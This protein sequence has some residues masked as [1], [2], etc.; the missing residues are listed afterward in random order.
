MWLAEVHLAP[1]L[2]AEKAVGKLGDGMFA[3]VRV[4]VLSGDVDRVPRGSQVF[5]QPVGYLL[6]THRVKTE[7]LE[8]CLDIEV[9]C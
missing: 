1:K 4:D 9:H 5:F 7:T 2:I 3:P 8:A 6:S